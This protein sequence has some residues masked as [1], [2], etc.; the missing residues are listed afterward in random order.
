MAKTN[1]Q[2]YCS[3]CNRTMNASEFYQ[4]NNLEKYPTKYLNQCK[5][6]ITMHVDN[7]NPETYLW[8]LQEVDVPYVPEEWYKLLST[9]GKDRSKVTGMTIIGRYL[10]K[11]KLK[12]WN[13]YRWKDSDFLQELANS[14]MEQ[15][16]K[17][18]GFDAQQ[19]TEAVNRAS[20]DI[21]T[22]EL[23]IPEEVL[24]P[25]QT[26]KEQAYSTPVYNYMPPPEPIEDNSIEDSLTDDEKLTLRIKWGKTYKPDEWV[27][28]EKLYNE[29][30]ESYD[31]QSAG[32]IDTLKMIC[33]TSLKANQLLDIGDV[34]GAQKMVKMYDMLMKSG[35]FTAAQNKTES[36][37]AVDSISELVAL[38]EKDGFFPR[39][40]V[41]GPQDKV[42]RTLQDLQ[43]YTRQL[44]TEEMNL[45][46]LIESAVKQIQIDKEKEA[47]QDADAANDDEVFEA[48]LF[49]EENEKAYLKDEDF[50]QL[51][52]LIEEDEIDDE[53]YL[54]SL[55]SDDQEL[56]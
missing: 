32:H 21:P 23:E 26:I 42:D 51:N 50:Q 4:S 41:D 5:K 33:K 44:V 55:I 3:K 12:Q 9:Y 52:E 16:M 31:I 36:G 7:W 17:R 28:L 46:N 34:D 18:Q 29:M 6:C 11:M 53:E 20:F 1:E 47:L 35:K 10:S 40:Y 24:Q 45:G 56:I 37:N 2:C 19:I 54:E 22:E 27:Q 13:Q 25:G 15:A 30:M 8:I 38:C 48:E 39:Y 14:K 43:K 49:D